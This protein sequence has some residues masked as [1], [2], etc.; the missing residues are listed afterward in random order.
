MHSALTVK[1][2]C[3][4][5][6]L[7]SVTSAFRYYSRRGTI[8]DIRAVRAKNSSRRLFL[9]GEDVELFLASLTCGHLRLSLPTN[10][11]R[12]GRQ[13]MNVPCSFYFSDFSLFPVSARSSSLKLVRF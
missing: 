6:L 2:V 5:C 13:R 1:S 10:Q 11:R 3:E 7:S 9:L 12:G 4:Q 8:E